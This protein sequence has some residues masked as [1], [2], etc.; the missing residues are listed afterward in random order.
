MNSNEIL[1]DSYQDRIKSKLR[2]ANW[3]TLHIDPW[4]TLALLCLISFGLIILYS[5]SNQTPGIVEKQLLR[6]GLGFAVMFIF[7]QIPPQ[8]Y[9]QWT[10]WL[11]IAG[12]LLLVAVLFIGQV[13]QGAR[14]WFDLKLFNLQ[15]SEIMKLATPMMLAWFL[16]EKTLPP[17][18][19][20]VLLG[21]IMMIIPVLLTAKQPDL[22]TAILIAIAGL[23]V[24]ILAGIS[25]PLVITIL[26]GIASAAPFIWHHMHGYQRNRILTLINPESD[27][28]GSGYHIIQSKIA[29]GSGGVLGKGWL[30]G[31]QSHLSFLPAHTTDFI[32]AVTGEEFGLFGCVL[33]LLIFLAILARCLYISV[34]AQNTYGRLLAG[35]LSFTFIIGALINIGMVIGILPVVGI[36]LP[37]VSYGGSSLLTIMAGFGIIMSIHGHRKLWSK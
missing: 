27:P 32:F 12:L 8:R 28:L 4:L 22:G 19:R 23:F 11:F 16:S 26:L 33:L 30:Q 36:P 17:K 13:Q 18:F 21:G 3:N 20:W 14:R 24:L 6:L 34:K 35:S 1:T 10:P 25:W 31:S 7:A 5:A 2:R 9:Y 37:L 15:P 29:I